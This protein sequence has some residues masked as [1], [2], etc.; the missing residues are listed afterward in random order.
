MV[1]VVI[2]WIEEELTLVDLFTTKMEENCDM[3]TSF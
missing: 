1:T 3:Y 2:G